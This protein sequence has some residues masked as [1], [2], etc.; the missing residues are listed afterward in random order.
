VVGQA[1]KDQQAQLLEAIFDLSREEVVKKVNAGTLSQA[2]LRAHD[3]VFD[4][5]P[6]PS[7]KDAG[8]PQGTVAV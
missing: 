8:Q 2:A 4:I 1:P 5:F 6:E 7:G 3:Y